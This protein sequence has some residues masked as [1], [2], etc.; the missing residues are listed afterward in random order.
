M[1]DYVGDKGLVKVL[2][3]L[4]SENLRLD[5]SMVEGKIHELRSL[6]SDDYRHL[7]SCIFAEM[8]KID[9][10]RQ[11]EDIAYLAENMRMVYDYSEQHYR[12]NGNEKDKI[13][14]NKIKKLYDHI[15]LEFARLQY[16]K[17][18]QA[19][20]SIELNRLQVETDKKVELANKSY[21]DIKEKVSG[22][23]KDY[24]AILGIFASIV[25]TFMATLNLA[26]SALASLKDG[27]N[28][29]TLVFIVLLVALFA[30]NVLKSLFDFLLKITDRENSF[31]T[32]RLCTSDFNI[33]FIV[34]IVADYILYIT[35]GCN[36]GK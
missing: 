5:D 16:V 32:V 21:N 27:T 33:I 2:H 12:A 19:G 11:G 9:K 14:A 29:Y 28:F 6:Y 34:L 13:F 22:L 4:A 35:F 17:E 23:Q 26:N 30:F 36:I 25:V 18:I 7:Y 3:A 20:N 24:I 10:T 8:V 31:D 1:G 15:N